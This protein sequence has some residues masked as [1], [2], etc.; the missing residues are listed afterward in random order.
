[1]KQYM[2]INSNSMASRAN[3]LAFKERVVTF[4]LGILAA[5]L[6]PSLHLAIYN[7]FWSHP[8]FKDPVNRHRC[9]CSCWDMLFKGSYE[10]GIQTYK[11]VYFNLTSN[12]FWIWSVTV[13]FIIALYESV[14]YLLRLYLKSRLR[15]SMLALYIAVLY[16]HYYAWWSYFNYINDDFYRQWNHQTFFS[17]TELLST[18]VVLYLCDGKRDARPGYLLIIISIAVLHILAASGDQFIKNVILGKGENFQIVRD[19][20]FMVPDLLNI[21]IPFRLWKHWCRDQDVAWSESITRTELKL[22]ALFIVLLLVVC[23]IL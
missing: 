15:V 23:N 4:F 1:M 22:S 10:L 13:L 20:G 18:L 2:D 11:H 16:S 7:R 21:V 17:V 14:C 3:T 19:I 6:M 9:T 5:I 8:E 12:T